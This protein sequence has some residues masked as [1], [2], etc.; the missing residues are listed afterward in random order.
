MI[1]FSGAALDRAAASRRRP[2]WLEARR[3][4]PRARAVLMS[5]SRLITAADLE[6]AAGPEDLSSFDLRVARARA[7]RDVIQ[8]ALA[9]SDGRLSTAAR[10]LGVSRPTLYALLEAH[11]LSAAT[12]D[13]DRDQ[14][15]PAADTAA[16]QG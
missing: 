11:G 15:E 9:R 10:L 5:D 2:D 4:D 7:E 6:L 3:A 8:R 1:V 13:P 14:V 12:S 16:T